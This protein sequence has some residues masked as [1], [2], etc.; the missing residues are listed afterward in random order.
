MQFDLQNLNI[1][2]N[3]LKNLSIGTSWFKQLGQIELM[4]LER[5]M[6]STSRASSLIKGLFEVPMIRCRVLYSARVSS[7]I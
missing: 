5:D 1:K 4:R 2:S 6:P 3:I 7:H